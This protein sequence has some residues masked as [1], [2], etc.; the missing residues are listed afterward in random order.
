MM[1]MA[2]LIPVKVIVLTTIFN[3]LFFAKVTHSLE[4]QLIE[5]YKLIKS[6]L[7]INKFAETE[8]YYFLFGSIYIDDYEDD[9]EFLAEANAY[10]NLDVY[11]FKKIC[12]PEYLNTETKLEIFYQFLNSKPLMKENKNI[13]I[14][15]KI[16]KQNNL[17]NYIFL[18]DKKNNKISFPKNSDLGF[19]NNCT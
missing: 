7:Q 18:F 13:K 5:E 2:Q 15:K 19:L 16:K 9:L 8:H 4:A 17:I 11:A 12:W 6:D 3:L 1:K 14:L 10:E